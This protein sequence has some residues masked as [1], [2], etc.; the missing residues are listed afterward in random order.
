MP[1]FMTAYL[2]LVFRRGQLPEALILPCQVE[3][4]SKKAAMFGNGDGRGW[5]RGACRDVGDKEGGGAIF[6]CGR[7]G[8][9]RRSVKT[10]VGWGD[11]SKHVV[12]APLGAKSL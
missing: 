12:A 4:R 2:S 11:Q 6:R 7:E 9:R 1:H 10:C 5:E 8:E 3:E